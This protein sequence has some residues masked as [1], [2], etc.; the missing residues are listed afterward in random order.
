MPV[1]R[2]VFG[3]ET[4]EKC[5]R[6]GRENAKNWVLICF[7][8]SRICMQLWRADR[9]C[10]TGTGFVY[11]SHNQTSCSSATETRAGLTLPPF[12]MASGIGGPQLQ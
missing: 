12:R 3:L 6:H 8:L 4:A 2:S 1:G 11:F 9:L 5:G 7:E 10:V